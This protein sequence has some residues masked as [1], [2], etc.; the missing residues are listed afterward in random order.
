MLILFLCSIWL[1]TFFISEQLERDMADQIEKQQFSIASYMANIIENQVKLRISS[2]NA[3]ASNITPELIAYPNK[4]REFLRDRLLL[5]TLF[6]TGV[7]VISKDGNGIADYPA[8]SGRGGASYTALE[9]FKEV[10]ATK[11]PSVGKPR[12][13]RFSKKPGIGFAVPVLTQSGELIAVLAGY[14]LLSDPLLFGLFENSIYKDFP[15]GLLLSSPKYRMHII[16]SDS[17]RIMTPT[18]E[19]RSCSHST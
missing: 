12:I 6:Q 15:D 14:A 10:V 16:G 1:L 19:R 4:L 2:L 13:G 11:R 18:P 9:Y 17:S 5:S 3:I 8:L 7:V